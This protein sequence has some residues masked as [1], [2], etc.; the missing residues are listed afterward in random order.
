MEETLEDH[1]S[2]SLLLQFRQAPSGIEI[3][4]RSQNPSHAG[5]SDPTT[6][7]VKRNLSFADGPSGVEACSIHVLRNGSVGHFP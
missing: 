2:C 5:W 7:N 4:A 1:R 3:R 6:I